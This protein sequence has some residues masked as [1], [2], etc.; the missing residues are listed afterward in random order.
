MKNR[1]LFLDIDGVLNHEQF[2]V[3]VRNDKK[4]YK[5]RSNKEEWLLNQLD[6]NSI[7][8]LNDFIDESGCKL[9]LSSSWRRTSFF[10]SDDVE[11]TIKDVNTFF[12]KAGV[13]GE[14]IG[15]TRLY[16]FEGSFRG[17]EIYSWIND[18]KKT[19]SNYVIFDDDSDMLYWQRNNFF[20]VDGVVGLTRNVCYRALR[21]LNGD[22]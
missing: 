17:N 14:F 20:L 5:K 16:R 10:R 1:I 12:K 22:I 19:I 9:V 8:V 2:Y 7:K 6:P 3:R 13:V 15:V 18:N 21:F 4:E 11:N